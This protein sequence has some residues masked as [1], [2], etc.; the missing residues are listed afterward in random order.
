MAENRNVLVIDE[1][2]GTRESCAKILAQAGF[3]ASSA[4]TRAAGAE[5][6]RQNAFRAIVID[7]AMPDDEGLELFRAAAVLRPE[8]AIIAMSGERNSLELLKAARDVGAKTLLEKPFSEKELL[9]AVS[10]AL[11]SRLTG[12]ERRDI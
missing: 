4:G 10:F 5:L 3:V 9:A 7:I 2:M 11:E 12:A 8:N 6:M 1:D